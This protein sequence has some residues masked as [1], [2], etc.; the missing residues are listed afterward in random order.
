M[1]IDFDQSCLKIGIRDFVTFAQSSYPSTPVQ[2][3][4][5]WRTQLG[6]Q[7]HQQLWQET[8]EDYGT[9]AEAEISIEGV[10]EHK[11]WKFQLSGRIDQLLYESQQTVIREI[12]TT[13]QILPIP[14]D[15]LKAHYPDYLEQLAC[16]ELLIPESKVPPGLPLISELLM[17]HIDTG[18][19]Q[20]IK[21][22]DDP[23][24][25]LSTRL[26]RWVDFLEGQRKRND[27]I[28]HLVVPE[29]F[30][31]FRDDQIPVRQ[32][33]FR[34]LEGKNSSHK[35]RR[36]IA[37]Q[38]ATGFG[39]TSIALEW[40]LQGIQKGQFERVIYLTGKNT[41]QHQVTKELQ[42]FRDRSEGIRFFQ[43][44]NRETHHQV[45]PHPTCVCQTRDF[46]K[47]PQLVSYVPW[48]KVNELVLH[49]SPEIE[50]IGLAASSY[51]VCP[52]LISQTALAI[53]EF[54]I[55]DYNYVFAPGARALL[56]SIPTFDAASTLLILDEAHNLHERV[57]ANFSTRF[58]TYQGE[59][60]IAA[61]RD[62]RAPRPFLASLDALTRFVASLKP[63]TTLDT[64]ESYRLQD[65]L[66]DVHQKLL[67]NGRTLVDLPEAIVEILWNLESAWQSTR[68]SS[69][70]MMV[71]CSNS[72]S[73]DLTC[74]ESNK[75]IG[76]TLA[77]FQPSLFMSATF[78][79]SE[80]FEQQVCIP[81][82][83]VLRIESPSEWRDQCYQ[84]AIDARVNTNYKNREHHY[85][86]TAQALIRLS[87]SSNQPAIS[88][89]PSYRYAETIA[90]YVE[91][92]APHL[93]VFTMSRSLSPREQMQE[94]EDAVLGNDVLC[95]PLGSG[96]SEGIDLL[97]GRVDTVMVV[98]PALPEVNPVQQAKSELY[99]HSKEGFREVYQIPGI[100]KVNQ[101]LGRIVRDPS[102]R[103]RV[104]LHCNRFAQS[105]YR[106]LLSTEYQHA[107][108]LRNDQEFEQWVL[109]TGVTYD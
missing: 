52:R 89:Y 95:L 1:E 57:C 60:L 25:I 28:Q 54:W 17:L 80:T 75:L 55:A 51:Q 5:N 63:R 106:T 41:G 96:L 7:W 38:A 76:E 72:G 10:I 82:S 101:A 98:S 43:I 69:L 6:Q 94:I 18:I 47:Q 40:A 58:T 11:H 15:D 81:A 67:E 73:M 66:E 61:L 64:T 85:A 62:L 4:G 102:H 31:T 59:Q 44:R 22:P 12:K 32:L 93:R 24:G 68:N 3:V 45:C 39:K 33:L 86:T 103:A 84:V 37:L 90:T 16:Y 49:G 79:S 77:E 65:L 34:E 100:T 26:D 8:Q 50:T 107:T 74:I 99:A 108:V 29:A 30:E 48:V 23:M 104:L 13:Q 35:K 53:T 19:R 36:H 20:I 91:E 97:G 42:R 105:E 87:E 9:E 46:E 2:N 78:P 71:W 56:D 27:R 83:E 109:E 70:R 14:L 88:F 21:L 92:M